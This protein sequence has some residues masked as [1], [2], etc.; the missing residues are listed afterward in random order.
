V[1]LK[2][3]AVELLRVGLADP[4]ALFRDG[5]W[6]AI[7]AIVNDK[8]RIL[9]VQRTG[10]GKSIVY[11]ISTRLFRDN[12]AGLTLLISPLL[13]L[14]RNQLQA[15]SRMGV[16]AETINSSNPNEWE[17]VQQRILN[18]EV[19]ILLISPE[20]LA[21][22]DFREKLLMP[23]AQGI[24]M[25]VI[26]EAHCISDWGHDFR[27]D[28]RRIVR[29][30]HALPRNIPVLATTATAN[31]RVVR[32]VI[33]QLGAGLRVVRGPLARESL[34][35]Q[36][37]SL[38]SQSARLAWLAEK[39]P[40][41]PGS[42]IIYT[43]TVKDAQRVAEWLRSQ[44]IDAHAYWGDLD[45]EKREALEQKL[46]ENR[47]KALVATTAL[48]MGFDKPD[49]G[50]VV[51][52][53]RPGS[54][55][56]YYQQVGRAGRALEHAY[57]ILLSGVEDDDITDYFIETAFPPQ[58]HVDELLSALKGV[59]RGMYLT[60]L[61]GCLNLRRG[62]IDKV[63]KI[64]SVETP[65]PVAKRGS[66]WFATPVKYKTDKEKIERL[67]K[68]RI[69]EQKRMREYI[70]SEGCLMSFLQKEL[71]DPA[72]AS[73]GRC[74]IC[75]GKPLLSVDYNT[76]IAQKASEFLK[77]MDQPI[78]PRKT[79]PGDALI[80]HYGWKGRILIDLQLEEG[81]ALCLWGDAGWGQLVRKG[82]QEEDHFDDELVI[83]A[84][85][86]IRERWQPDPSPQWVTC[87]PSL[88]RPKLVAHFAER[89]AGK[90]GLPMMACIHKKRHTE[91]QKVMQNSYQQARNLDGAFEVDQGKVIKG[92]SVLLVDDI[93][94]SG[95]TLT[96]L[97]ALLRSKGSGPVFPF[98]LAMA[99]PRG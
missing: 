67:K 53:Q 83:A 96:V 38:P 86:L 68:I 47:V 91:P 57:G 39:V 32:D 95:W 30:L 85:E 6:E 27:P 71:D 55:V 56:H 99:T 21:N 34:R 62:Q 90:L 25:F 87:V 92:A 9:L 74:A 26:D 82:K 20:R 59:E 97:G 43:L 10:W 84:S 66:R 63:L 8:A 36:N 58:A 49:L 37:I 31:D 48:G 69:D 93:V 24:G 11:F 88:N 81:R 12:K 76:K 64:L 54:V 75:N 15:A 61:E 98:T 78:I 50:F 19:D 42:G 44:D 17:I 23:M 60:E 29:V 70:E 80:E 14:M 33:D 1:D 46:L 65:S 18:N 4:N 89:L 51:H 5:Q 28:Y 77:R 13:A 16:Q 45:S 94:D 79:W 72:S 22:E 7:S 52:F 2:K 41:M 40:Q 35:L 3:K 73:C